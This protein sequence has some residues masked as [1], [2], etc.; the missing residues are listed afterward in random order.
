[1]N[2]IIRTYNLNNLYLSLPYIAKFRD[3]NLI[4]HNDNPSA[5]LT[6]EMVRAIEPC[7]KVGTIVNE[8]KNLGMFMSFIRSIQEADRD[9]EY[10]VMFDDDDIPI[11]IADLS[12]CTA[13]LNRP[14]R[15]DMCSIA[16]YIKY[17]KYGIIGKTYHFSRYLGAYWNTAFLCDLAETICNFLPTFNEVWGGTY[18]N[19]NEDTVMYE[20]TKIFYQESSYYNKV[21][22]KKIDDI[23]LIYNRSILPFSKHYAVNDCMYGED[24]GDKMKKFQLFIKKLKNLLPKFRE[25]LRQDVQLP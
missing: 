2:L 19:G 8:T 10:T 16:D 22:D 4:I 14:L 5:V 9:D 7:L 20:M 6:N 23:G 3:Y 12:Q 13:L 21:F 15:S 11:P 25:F 24:R 1:M 17:E 18:I